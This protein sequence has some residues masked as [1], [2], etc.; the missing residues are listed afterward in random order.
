LA[1]SPVGAAQVLTHKWELSRRIG[2]T[3]H[4][5]RRIRRLFSHAWADGKRPQQLADALTKA[6]LRLWF[7]A[8]EINDFAGITRAVTEG[9]ARSKVL[10][11]A[12]FEP[13]SRGPTKTRW[14]LPRL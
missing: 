14:H 11:S 5:R 2:A 6:G 8:A 10:L 1:P 3:S 4:G 12:I 13:N 9:L 7:D